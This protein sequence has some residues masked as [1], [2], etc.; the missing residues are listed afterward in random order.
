MHQNS[1]LLF[2]KYAL[3][4][5]RE[6]LSVLELGPDGNPSTFEMMVGGKCSRWDYLEISGVP[7]KTTYVT[8]SPCTFPIENDHFDIIVS[9]QVIEHVPHLWSWM[10]E[11]AR[12]CKPGGHVITIGPVSWFYHEAP[13]DCWR[14]YPEGMKALSEDFGLEVEISTWESVELERAFRWLPDSLKA[15]KVRFLRLSPLFDIAGRALRSNFRG[16]FDTITIARKPG[17]TV[18]KTLASDF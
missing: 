10:K 12:V 7:T 18:S 6:G 9:G 3:P 15:K 2:S 11:I 13:V 8:T 17:L 14:I 4:Y 1:W 5:F 16:A